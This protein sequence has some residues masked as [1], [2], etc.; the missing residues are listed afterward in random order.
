[1]TKRKSTKR[2]DVAVLP[3]RKPTVL[4]AD[5]RE[6]IL[7]AREG[8]ARAVDSGLTT[9]HWNVGRRI[10]LDIL[11]QKRA[12]YGQ[13]IVSALGTQLAGEFGRGFD[14]KSLRHMVRFAEA[15]PDEAIVSAL[16]RQLVWTHFK[17]LIYLDYPLKCVIGQVRNSAM[18]LVD[19]SA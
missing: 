18:I 13:Q 6:L 5:V 19:A 14:E 4:L 15:F 9:L 1:M 17:K 2:T 16:R 11:K 7:H 3:A 8:V 10:H 12:E